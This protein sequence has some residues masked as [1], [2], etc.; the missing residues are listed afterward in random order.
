MSL[1][2]QK[3]PD[4]I[5]SIIMVLYYAKMKFYC[6]VRVSKPG[7]EKNPRV[8]GRILSAAEETNIFSSLRCID[9]SDE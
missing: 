3:V 4:V 1:E 6:L 5:F 2:E 9:Y 7:Q 8:E